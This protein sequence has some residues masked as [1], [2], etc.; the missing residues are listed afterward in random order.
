[1][2]VKLVVDMN[3]SPDW[4][5]LLKSNGWSAVHWSTVG[6]PRASDAAIM[7]WAVS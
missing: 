4:V 3:Q 6:D 1:M 5:P 2:T 7:E